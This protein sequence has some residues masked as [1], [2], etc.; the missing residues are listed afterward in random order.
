MHHLLPVS[1]LYRTSKVVS[2]TVGKNNIEKLNAKFFMLEQPHLFYETQNCLQN[3]QTQSKNIGAE[4]SS[5]QNMAHFS[6]PTNSSLIKT[7][8]IERRERGGQSPLV[9][10][11]GSGSR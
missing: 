10:T 9:T 11:A 1:Y 6:N 3:I 8:P 7:S 4:G 2:D 5:V